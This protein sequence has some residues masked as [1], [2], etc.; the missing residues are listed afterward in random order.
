LPTK[1][2]TLRAKFESWQL[3]AAVVS[4]I[5][6]ISGGVA[7]YAY[8]QY[9]QGQISA[10]AAAE[11]T[12]VIGEQ[13]IDEISDRIDDLELAIRNSEQTLVNTDGQ[14]MDEKER[15]DLLAE[16]E[17]SKK[18]LVAQTTKLL[19]LEAAVKALKSQM[20]SGTPTRETIILLIGNISEV[21]NSDW[22]P[23]VTQIVALGEK[24]TS[25]QTAQASWLQD[26]ER[27]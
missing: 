15:E 25:V 6:L 13:R 21:A 26:M 17:A 18:V 4:S 16:I 9:T 24:I 2:Q 3:I 10:A 8:Q 7:V 14:T 11:E 12:I 5:T 27:L 1:K 19:E 22:M 23:I 20:A